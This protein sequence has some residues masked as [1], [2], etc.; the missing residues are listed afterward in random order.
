MKF[1]AQHKF[2]CYI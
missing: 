2:R 1:R